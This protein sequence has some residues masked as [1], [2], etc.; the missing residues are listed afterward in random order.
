M[1]YFSLYKCQA[2][3]IG[4]HLEGN[5]LTKIEGA[6]HLGFGSGAWVLGSPNF[7]I[8]RHLVFKFRQA[9]LTTQHFGGIHD[10]VNNGFVPCAAANIVM[11]G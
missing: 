9:Y 10:S 4:G 6:G 8:G 1:G 2:Q 5:V 11:L 3:G 7:A